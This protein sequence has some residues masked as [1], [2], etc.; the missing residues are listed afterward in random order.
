ML[1]NS[2]DNTGTVAKAAAF[3]EEK[4]RMPELLWNLAANEGLG[5]RSR[6]ASTQP[7]MPTVLT[8]PWSAS[9]TCKEQRSVTS[10]T[11]LKEQR[12]C[13]IGSDDPQARHHDAVP[14]S[15]DALPSDQGKQPE[16]LSSRNWKPC[17]ERQSRTC[18]MV[19]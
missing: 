12:Q 18:F 10:I 16:G 13:A 11:K 17:I 5:T 4:Q 9:P 19:A 7:P 2:P 8:H 14:Y 1:Q 15:I 6:E 3:Q